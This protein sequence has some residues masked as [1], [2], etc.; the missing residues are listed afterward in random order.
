MKD[1]NPMQ[2]RGV[3]QVMEA[4]G[5]EVEAAAAQA[6]G[7]GSAGVEVAGAVSLK[8]KFAFDHEGKFGFAG[9]VTSALPGIDSP[10]EV[11]V[12][13]SPGVGWQAAGDGTLE[14]SFS[15]RVLLGSDDP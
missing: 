14:A 2:I 9:T 8:G 10:T 15:I 11:E 5:E 13:E 1:P 3:R 6:A 4:L 12:G 7:L